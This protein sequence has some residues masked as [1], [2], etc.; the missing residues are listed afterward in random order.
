MT[1]LAAPTRTVRR[2]SAPRPEQATATRLRAGSS[3][4]ESVRS[5]ATERAIEVTRAP[6]SGLRFAVLMAVIAFG[7]ILAL[8]LL[9]TARAEQSFTIGRLNA[10]VATLQDRQEALSSELDAVSAPEELSIRAEKLGMKHASGVVFKDK[11]NGRVIGVAGSSMPGADINVNT[12]PNTP[13]SNAATAMLK[14]GTVGLHITDP[15]AQAAAEAKAKAAAAAAD[16]KQAAQNKK[17]DA[18]KT[19]QKKN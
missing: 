17:A 11:A 9:N 4:A 14:S 5:S 6:R 16:Q 2:T 1:Q 15:V 3:R 13:A 10:D 8:L 7:S 19:S 18:A 12:L